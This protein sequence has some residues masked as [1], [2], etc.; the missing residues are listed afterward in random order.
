MFAIKPP[1]MV[2]ECS[3][4]L[5]PLRNLSG[6]EFWLHHRW[7]TT[8]LDPKENTPVENSR[9]KGHWH[10]IWHFC[11]KC[12]KLYGVTR[13][14]PSSEVG[15]PWR[16]R[17]TIR[18]RG[19]V[20][21]SIRCRRWLLERRGTSAGKRS[22]G[23]TAAPGRT[24]PLKTRLQRQERRKIRA[25]RTIAPCLPRLELAQFILDKRQALPTD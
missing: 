19:R 22:A 6:V 3:T 24:T 21:G 13:S 18:R 14:D 12:T 8:F 2:Q 7:F 4:A 10:F 9:R 23:Q 20:L 15:K 25:Q 5:R 11:R 16:I 1:S 17:E